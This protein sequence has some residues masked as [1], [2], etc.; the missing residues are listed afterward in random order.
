VSEHRQS[1]TGAAKLQV[2]AGFW[3]TGFT[4]H[5]NAS[6]GGPAAVGDRR[7][8]ARTGLPFAPAELSVSMDAARRA[9]GALRHV[10]K[11]SEDF[12]ASA[13]TPQQTCLA[14]SGSSRLGQLFLWVLPY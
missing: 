8:K 10:V 13:N 11:R 2:E 6:R 3:R 7:D 14:G 12:A 1:H 9:A 5:P 4:L